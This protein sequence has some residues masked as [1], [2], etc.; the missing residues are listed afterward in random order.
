MAQEWAYPDKATPPGSSAYYCVRFAPRE[1]RRAAA[2]LFAWRGEIG[3]VPLRCSDP[4]VARLKLDWWREELARCVAA[5][6]RHPLTRALSPVVRRWDLP[7]A[8]FLEMTDA[9]EAAARG[10]PVAAIGDLERRLEGDQGALFELLGRVHGVADPAAL[11]ALRRLGTYCALVHL[12]R[13]AGALLRRRY[14]P[15]PRPW[16]EE[17][18]G[19]PRRAYR[20]ALPRLAR[21]A[22]EL[23]AGAPAAVPPGIAARVAILD[24]LLGELEGS[25]FPVLDQRV[26]LTPLRKVWIGWRASRAARR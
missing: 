22:R 8:P 2:L 14:D 19:D 6:A 15:L 21:R 23:R 5:Q 20:D 7:P 3:D 1:L 13:D 9:A 4:G 25:G 11:E 24:A 10:E 16:V 18:A 12:I 17:A 26:G